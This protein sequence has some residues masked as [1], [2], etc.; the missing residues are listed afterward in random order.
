MDGFLVRVNA[1]S[2]PIHSMTS[3]IFF[4]VI[5]GLPFARR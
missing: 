3:L 2:L 5:A 4:F 1:V